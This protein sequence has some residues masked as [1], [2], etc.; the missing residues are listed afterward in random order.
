M[1]T[2]IMLD[3]GQNI[4]SVL[5]EFFKVNGVDLILDSPSRRRSPTGTRRALVHDQ[6]DG[7][8]INFNGDYPGGVTIDGQAVTL[9]SSSTNATVSLKGIIKR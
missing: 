6:N 8:T 9:G 7:L 2:D 4:V 1:P 5:T 3:D